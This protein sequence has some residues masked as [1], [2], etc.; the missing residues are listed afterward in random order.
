EREQL[1]RDEVVK[2]HRPEQHRQA[3]AGADDHS[4]SDQQRARL[5]RKA[6]HVP[7]GERIQKSAKGKLFRD[8]EPA[9][10]LLEPLVR[11]TGLLEL[12]DERAPGPEQ[13]NQPAQ[14]KGNDQRPGLMQRFDSMRVKAP[15]RFR[16]RDA[17][18]KL[19]LFVVDHLPL[20]WDGDEDA[21]R[22]AEQDKRRENIPGLMRTRDEK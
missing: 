22:S 17:A 16:S 6:P 20:H 4:R 5:E 3:D 8:V 18:R 10:D 19:Q 1:R 13:R 2:E 7:F 14:S 11:S 21:Q 9:L 12:R 15:E